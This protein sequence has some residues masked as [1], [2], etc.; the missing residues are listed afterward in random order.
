MRQKILPN[1][2]AEKR[3]TQMYGLDNQ[4][5]FVPVRNLNNVRILL[6]LAASKDWPMQ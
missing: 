4:K 2:V 3:Y 1:K 5:T 6:S